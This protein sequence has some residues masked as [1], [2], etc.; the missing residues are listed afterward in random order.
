MSSEYHS[1]TRAQAQKLSRAMI[2]QDVAM[3]LAE[4]FAALGDST[5]VRILDLLSQSEL[6]VCDLARLLDMTASAIS[7]Q[8][9]YLRALRLVKFRKDGKNTL[10][11]L[12]DDHIVALFG[13]GLRHV[14]HKS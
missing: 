1:L 6:C 14:R 9:R 11:S 12:D 13:E 8:L 7:H 5:R 10:Y 2:R 3:Q 4:T